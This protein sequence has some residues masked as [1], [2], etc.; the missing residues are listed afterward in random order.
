MG[1]GDVNNAKGKG[2]VVERQRVW[3]VILIAVLITVISLTFVFGKDV[4]YA[5]KGAHIQEKLAS[6]YSASAEEQPGV[7][8]AEATPEP[9]VIHE[10]FLELYEQNPHL[11]GWL[12]AAENVNY[13]IVQS[14]NEFYLDHDFYGEHDINGTIF[15]NSANILNPRDQILLIHGHNMRSGAMLS[16]LDYFRDEAY[17]GEHPLI[18]FRTIY[19]P[20]EVFYV[21]VAAFDASVDPYEEG[22]YDITRLRFEYD[23]LANE[24]QVTAAPVSETQSSDS[25][26]QTED[27]QPLVEKDRSTELEL[28]IE[29]IRGM[30]YWDSPVEA[31]S[32]DQYI[33]LVTCSYQHNDGRMVLLCRQLRENETPEEMEALFVQTFAQQ[34]PEADEGV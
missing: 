19:D 12:R 22:Y 15:V 14:D 5:W 16:D 26:A 4:F 3:P 33:A 7:G 27:G 1:Q 17:V 24:T 13:P 29:E 30:S 2:M 6:M 25:V 28:Y 21:P 34:I 32:T 18:M 20:E 23:I 11:I 10:D 8:V 9:L 31:D